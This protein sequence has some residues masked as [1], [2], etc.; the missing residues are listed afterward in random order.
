[1][2]ASVAEL[3]APHLFEHRCLFRDQKQLERNRVF[4]ELR[5]RERDMT[6]V[7]R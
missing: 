7:E 2:S 4:C 1:V 3:Q 5:D 6:G